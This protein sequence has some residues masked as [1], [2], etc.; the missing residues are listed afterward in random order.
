MFTRISYQIINSGY[1]MKM[2]IY[3]L[4]DVLIG[5]MIVLSKLLQVVCD[6]GGTLIYFQL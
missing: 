1:R 4:I 6:G 2:G 5:E 3:L